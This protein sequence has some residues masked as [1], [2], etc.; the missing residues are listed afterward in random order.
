MSTIQMFQLDGKEYRVESSTMQELITQLKPEVR[1]QGIKN[2][3]QTAGC[4]AVYLSEET[5]KAT[6]EMV[7]DE[8]KGDILA[9]KPGFMICM[10][11]DFVKFLN[12]KEMNAI[13][14]HEIGHIQA[15]H[16]DP[17]NTKGKSG[18]ISTL[19]MECQADDFMATQTEPKYLFT[20]IEKV[21]ANVSDFIYSTAKKKGHEI[22]PY[23]LFEKMW[24]ED[25]MKARRQRFGF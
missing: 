11:Q 3:L 7:T 23:A 4:Y 19:E 9:T 25:T 10:V 1:T 12:Q 22:D 17:Q 15:G 18:I 21:L 16:L 2:I 24:A 13:L 6:A 8:V 14:Y 20:G 5:I